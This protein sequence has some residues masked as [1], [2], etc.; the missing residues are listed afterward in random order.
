MMKNK[1]KLLIILLLTM[2]VGVLFATT[3]F[4][5]EGEN[6]SV[7]FYTTGGA[8]DKNINTSQIVQGEAQIVGGQTVK[9]PTKD[10]ADGQSFNWRTEDGRC[11]EGGAT[12][13]FYESTILFPITATDVS[14]AEEL[15]SFTSKSGAVIRLLDDIYVQTKP[16]FPWPGSIYIILNGKTLEI[17]SSLGTAWGGQRAGTYFYGTGTVKYMGTGTFANMNGHGYGGDNCR[18]FIG[19]GVTID[20][21]NSILGYDGDGSYV[22][23]Y[24]Y[25]QIYGIVNC[26]TVLHMQN[27]GNRN[28]R[29]EIYDGAQLNI[30]GALNT[31]ASAGNVVNVIVN[32]GNIK[33]TGSISFFNDQNANYKIKGG[34]F[35]FANQDDYSELL[36]KI[37]ISQYRIIEIKGSNKTVYQTVSAYDECR[38][39]YVL[40]STTAASCGSCTKDNFVCTVC[41]VNYVTT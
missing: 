21:P 20:A 35:E 41:N 26:K 28:P 14:T 17:N 34:S 13:T 29:I 36:S 10:V 19:A 39:E 32:G 6:I 22:S 38:H 7:K 1:G 33:T 25:I 3:A 2:I 27:S 15:A 40:H 9:L 12:V 8:L 30:S 24:P 11:W 4:A 23:G 18:L 37:D 5:L 31:H 16:G